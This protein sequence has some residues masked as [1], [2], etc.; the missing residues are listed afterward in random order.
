MDIATFVRRFWL[1]PPADGLRRGE[2]SVPTRRPTANYDDRRTKRC[3]SLRHLID[4]Y[5]QRRHQHDN[6]PNRPGEESMSAGF[7]TDLC[8]K[9]WFGPIQLS[10]RNTTALSALIPLYSRNKPALPDFN[11]GRNSPQTSECLRQMLDFRL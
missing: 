7:D 9:P 3:Y 10:S 11:D 2:R 1:A 8:G 4:G 5:A 6:I